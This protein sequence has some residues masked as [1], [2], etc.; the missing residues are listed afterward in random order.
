MS[1]LERQELGVERKPRIEKPRR[2]GQE[3]LADILATRKIREEIKAKENRV[4][5]KKKDVRELAS[6]VSALLGPR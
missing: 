3:R 4:K 6:L 2:T 1:L 5:R